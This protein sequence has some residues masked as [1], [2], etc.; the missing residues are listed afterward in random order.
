M[1]AGPGLPVLCAYHEGH[2]I[3]K[4]NPLEAPK[5]LGFPW[6]SV[7]SNVHCGTQQSWSSLTLP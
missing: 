1:S 2:T 3:K 7:A 4:P 6:F 5:G